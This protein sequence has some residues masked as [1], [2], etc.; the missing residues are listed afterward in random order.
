MKR[1]RFTFVELVVV[2]VIVVIAGMLTCAFQQVQ[3]QVMKEA[4]IANMRNLSLD[5]A[6]YSAN[7]SGLIPVQQTGSYRAGNQW[8]PALY[9]GKVDKALPSYISCP[10]FD[11]EV[12]TRTGHTYGMIQKSNGEAYDNAYGNAWEVQGNS[13]A[14]N[15]R[16]IKLVSEYVLFADSVFGNPASKSYG[17]QFYSI[18]NALRGLIH[19]RH[20]DK[21]NVIFA[22]G[23]VEPVNFAK[24]RGTYFKLSTA[25]TNQ[26][27]YAKMD[28]LKKQE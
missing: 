8:A 24:M 16:K 9:Q 14:L 10:E 19:F 25:N 2:I 28:F 20:N 6:I 22:D 3:T 21:A 7:N 12:S 26:N 27:I 15:T 11:N 4:C 1:A 23:H 5:V 18:D 17:K 13:K